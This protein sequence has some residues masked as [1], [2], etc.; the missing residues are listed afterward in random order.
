[1]VIKKELELQW[2]TCNKN[3][4]AKLFKKIKK[5]K[6]ITTI[7]ILSVIF[8][9]CSTTKNLESSK[10]IEFKS[11]AKNSNSGFEKL[12]QEVFNNQQAFEKV[13]TTAWS[14]FS[15]PTPTP[16]IDFT[17]E[18]IIL[19]ALGIKNNGG[20]QLKMNSVHE[21]DNE[22][23]IDYTELTPNAKCSTTQAIVFPYEFISIPK[24][25]NKIVFK[26]SEQVGDCN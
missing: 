19:V 16:S 23:T 4:E 20:Y 26:P 7:I 22:T 6:K 3:L 15:D 14:H 13:W 9:S 5:M 1:M 11:I 25:S 21:Q 18:T 24:T 10:H 17:K 8:I 2:A 12:T